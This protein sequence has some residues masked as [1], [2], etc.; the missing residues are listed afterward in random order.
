MTSEH[1][2]KYSENGQCDYDT[3]TFLAQVMRTNDN[4][5]TIVKSYNSD[6]N[7]IDWISDLGCTDHIMIDD[8][9]F[10]ELKN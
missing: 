7:R 5:A 3:G 4:K 2:A 1:D 10:T 8:N 6:M 9:Y